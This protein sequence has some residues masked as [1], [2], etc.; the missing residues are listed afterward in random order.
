MTDAP[1]AI[2]IPGKHELLMPIIT[3]TVAPGK[4]IRVLDLGAGEGA[5]SEKTISAWV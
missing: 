2:A 4:T 5:L 3:R 1:Q